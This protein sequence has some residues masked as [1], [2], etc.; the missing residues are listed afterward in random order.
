MTFD[1]QCDECVYNE[2]CPVGWSR[3]NA[4]CLTLRKP[5]KIAVLYNLIN[6]VLHG[7]KLDE[8]MKEQL[9]WD[10]YDIREGEKNE[11]IKF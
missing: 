10:Q 6:D 8:K 3:N 4:A 1:L 7:K 11:S 2:E 5:D 9:D